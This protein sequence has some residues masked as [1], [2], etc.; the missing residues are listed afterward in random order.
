MGVPSSAA[1]TWARLALNGVVLAHYF[2][3]AF[4]YRFK[5]PEVRKVALRRLG[6][7]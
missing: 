3:D 6:F 2:A 7:A 4:I 1:A 5:I